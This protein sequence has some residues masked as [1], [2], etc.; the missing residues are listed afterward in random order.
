MAFGKLRVL[1]EQI[2]IR[3]I[4]SRL[5]LV[6]IGKVMTFDFYILASIGPLVLVILS[7]RMANFMD[8]IAES[9]SM[10]S[11]VFEVEMHLLLIV[12]A[13][14]ITNPGCW[15]SV[16][17][18]DTEKMGMRALIVPLYFLF[19]DNDTVAGPFVPC[20]FEY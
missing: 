20:I 18:M 2:H 3:R 17:T 9:I 10:P 13:G 8:H 4:E 15:R 6:I 5:E 19:G 11:G 16:M 7:Q 14:Q 1:A 12:R